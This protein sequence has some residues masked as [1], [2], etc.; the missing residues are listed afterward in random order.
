[1]LS[2]VLLRL[3]DHLPIREIRGDDGTEYLERYYL[4]SFGGW[5]LY[6]HRFTASDPDR[7]LHNH[8]WKF[9]VSLILSGGYLETRLK[10]LSTKGLVYSYKNTRPFSLNF[11]SQNT[12][13]HITILKETWTLFLHSKRVQDWG[14]INT[15]ESV[16]KGW[17][18]YFELYSRGPGRGWEKRA[19]TGKEHRA[20]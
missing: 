3:S 15:A 2:K 1:M 20:V 13:H 17:M 11:I 7:G 19:L 14:F 9:S 12:F 6:L 8:P 16:H 4:M 5:K 18:G 10:E